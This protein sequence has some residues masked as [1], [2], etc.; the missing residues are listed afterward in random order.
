MPKVAIDVSERV[1]KTFGNPKT[2]LEA[3]KAIVGK[4]RPV[5]AT[6]FVFM[7]IMKLCREHLL[8]CDFAMPSI[9][10]DDLR[11]D[12]FTVLVNAVICA[13]CFLKG[14]MIREMSFQ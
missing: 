12:I 3:R 10:E 14:D 9:I 6:P 1:I 4:P 13:G 8:R 7:G 11:Q 2:T 5:T